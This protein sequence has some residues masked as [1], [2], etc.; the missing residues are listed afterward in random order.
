[1][2]RFVDLGKQLAADPSDKD[3]VR[4]FA[5]F[6]TESEKFIGFEGDQVFSSWADFERW[7]APIVSPLAIERLKAVTPQWALNAPRGK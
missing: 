3:A 1:M 2:I 5:Y 6:D 4:Q 7:I